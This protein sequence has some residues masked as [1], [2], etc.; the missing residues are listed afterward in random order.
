MTS[1]QAAVGKT[2]TLGSMSGMKQ[3]ADVLQGPVLLPVRDRQVVV[4]PRHSAPDPSL[5]MFMREWVQNSASIA[6]AI[7][8]RN[9]QGVRG[10]VPRLVP[11][12]PFQSDQK[13]DV[14]DP[15]S[16][17]IPSIE[18]DVEKPTLDT[19]LPRWK[20]LGKRRRLEFEQKK[21]F[22]FQRLK[23]RLQARGMKVPDST[24]I[25]T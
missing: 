2:N 22:G 8:T 5:Y 7:A 12:T 18:N 14:E 23:K 13:P 21:A 10:R 19:H 9:S 17:H 1:R 3:D 20:A 25:H 24:Y 15:Q 16:I 4:L 6:S 11:G